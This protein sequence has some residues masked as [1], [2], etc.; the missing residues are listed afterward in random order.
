MTTAPPPEPASD[1]IALSCPAK[2]NLAL[3]V[4]KPDSADERGLHPI[5]SWMVAVDFGDTLTVTRISPTGANAL[6]SVFSLGYAEDAP[7]PCAIDWPLKDDLVFRAHGLVEQHVGREL[8]VRADLEKRI[9]T[10]A[11]LGGG[12]SDAAGLI[13]ALD[14]LFD[15]NL[16][17]Q[18]YAELAGKLGSDVHFALAA[19]RGEPS[20]VV[21]GSG[22]AVR[23]AALPNPLDIALALPPFGCPTGPVYAAWDRLAP[24]AEHPLDVKAVE[25]L[26]RQAPGPASGF[27]N[28][29][30]PAAV[31]VEPQL[32]DL[33]RT[34][35]EDLG[36]PAH[37]TGSG[38]ACFV[39]AADAEAA[40]RLAAQ[41]TTHTGIPCVA[42]R[43]LPAPT[44]TP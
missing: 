29:L 28:D 40:S 20:A 17:V 19:L 5:A 24:D 35:R 34:L 1:K 11:G 41:I 9:P 26:A 25:D 39:P 33:L 36:L 14:Q 23:A 16:D 3:G 38:A 31:A 21:T 27:F 37:V 32:G 42:T 30:E 10:G 7:S 2:I 15:L 13:L 4:G 43:T 6:V 12:S 8:P 18:T 44:T 22:D